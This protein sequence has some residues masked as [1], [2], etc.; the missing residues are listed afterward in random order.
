MTY[1]SVLWVVVQP[2]WYEYMFFL[3]HNKL[4]YAVVNVE[5]QVLLICGGGVVP[6]RGKHVNKSI[7]LL[8]QFY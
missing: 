3:Y 1:L 5:S 6:W 8:H 2:S 7:V 4:Y